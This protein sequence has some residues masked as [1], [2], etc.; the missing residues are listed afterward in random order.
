MS[1]ARLE[2]CQEL[3]KLSK[4]KDT[5]SYWYQNWMF[6]NKWMVGHQGTPSIE[7]TFPAY[8]LGYLLRKLPPQTRIVKEYEASAELPEETPAHYHA[9]YDTVDERHF[10]LGADTPEDAACRLAI[11]LLKHGVIER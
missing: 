8:D 11:E 2:L 1:A 5:F 9:L 4:W 10:W 6:N 7:S 3:Y